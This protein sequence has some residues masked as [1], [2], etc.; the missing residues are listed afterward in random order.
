MQTLNWPFFTQYSLLFSFKLS[1]LSV[2]TCNLKSHLDFDNA[3]LN[4]H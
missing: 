2:L 4:I 1:R 3:H